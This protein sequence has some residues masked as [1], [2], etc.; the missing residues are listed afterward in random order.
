MRPIIRSVAAIWYGRITR[1]ILSL[2][3]T[4][5]LVRTFIRVCLAKK[6]RVKSIRSLIVLLLLSAQN[7][8]NSNELLVFLL[9]VL[10]RSCSLI[11]LKRV[12]LE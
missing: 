9:F 12:E 4:Q 3:K 8:E 7:D 10:F 11:W 5:Y 6:V 1:S 2:V